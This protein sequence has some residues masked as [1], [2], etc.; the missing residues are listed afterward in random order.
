[1]ACAGSFTVEL[2]CLMPLL[3]LV[4]FCVLG[5]GFWMH[6]KGYLTAAAYEAAIIGC[7]QLDKEDAREAALLRMQ[8][9][10]EA[11]FEPGS[12]G[13][14]QAEEKGEILEVTGRG[15][16]GSL[17]GGLRWDFVARGSYRNIRPVEFIRKARGVKE[18]WGQA[19][20]S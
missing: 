12:T 3:L 15:S 6:H 16:V 5:V 18:I 10:A 17:Y 1:M 9:R 8:E 14:L 7:G 13:Q 4:L 20:G 2:A 11:F 19:G